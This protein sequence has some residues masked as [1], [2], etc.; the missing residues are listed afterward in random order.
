MK[1]K[2]GTELVAKGRHVRD[3]DRRSVITE[4]HGEHDTP[5]FHPRPASWAPPPTRRSAGR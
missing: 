4:V 5:P 3:P 1:V 2:A